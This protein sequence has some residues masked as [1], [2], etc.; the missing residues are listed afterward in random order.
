VKRWYLPKIF[1]GFQ[2]SRWK[3]QMDLSSTTVNFDNL[4]RNENYIYTNATL[5]QKSTGSLIISFIEFCTINYLAFSHVPVLYV[6]E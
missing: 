1:G 6:T 3:F 2:F 5:I 4:K